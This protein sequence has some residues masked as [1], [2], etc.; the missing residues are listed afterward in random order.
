MSTKRARNPGALSKA[1]ATITEPC[2]AT[3]PMPPRT[4]EEQALVDGRLA[5]S[6]L[7]KA[8]KVKI[9]ERAALVPSSDDPELWVARLS[10]AAGVE[11]DELA[12]HIASQTADCIRG[13][14]KNEARF[15]LAT[16][17]IHSVAPTDGIE[18]ML[19]A[20]MVAT[21]H[22]AMSFLKKAEC[23]EILEQLHAS[24]GM[25]VKLLRTFTAQVEALS[26]Y[27][28]KGQQKVTV[29]HV[30]VHAG[31][32]AIVGTVT[33]GRGD[34]S[35]TEGQPHAIAHAPVTPVWS[36]EPEREAVPSPRDEEW[37]M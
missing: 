28:G 12:L 31:G 20:Q 14:S 7:S 2:E 25:A 33:G 19:A 11:D 37:P 15:N 30:H 26:R 22:A 34:A 9:N 18:S 23:A 10:M 35:K 6:R 4:L 16:A 32:Q 36:A 5:R 27:R 21:H 8:P 13:T 1:K 17:G 3:I 29:E 24:G